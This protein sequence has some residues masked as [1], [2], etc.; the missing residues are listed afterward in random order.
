MDL[1]WEKR[2]EVNPVAFRR[3]GTGYRMLAEVLDQLTHWFV[4]T[5]SERERFLR[6]RMTDVY[7]V[8]I[9]LIFCLLIHFNIKSIKGVNTEWC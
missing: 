2:I 3:H 5:G 9:K 4:H 1:I 8:L 6:N 7:L